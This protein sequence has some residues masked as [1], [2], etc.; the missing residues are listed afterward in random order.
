MTRPH[1][2]DGEA[3]SDSFAPGWIGLM[4]ALRLVLEAVVGTPALSRERR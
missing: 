2:E 4:A 1:A 3:A